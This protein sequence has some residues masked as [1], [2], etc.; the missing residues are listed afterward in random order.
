MMHVLTDTDVDIYSLY[1][2][3]IQLSGRVEVQYRSV[4]P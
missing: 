4:L 1:I 3:I 2:Y